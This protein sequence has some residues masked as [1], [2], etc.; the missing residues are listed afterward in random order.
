V[1]ERREDDVEGQLERRAGVNGAER[2]KGATCGSEEVEGQ[3][4]DFTCCLFSRK[5]ATIKK[6]RVYHLFQS[7]QVSAHEETDKTEKQEKRF[8]FEAVA[9]KN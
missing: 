5:M 1:R 4:G 2:R 8:G 3:N 7:V 9:A 6:W